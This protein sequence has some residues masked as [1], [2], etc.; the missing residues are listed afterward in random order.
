MTREECLTILGLPSQASWDEISI[1]YHDLSKVWHPDRFSDNERLRLFAEEKMKVIN[2][3]YQQLEKDPLLHAGTSAERTVRE[4]ADNTSAN[5][6]P[7]PE[8]NYEQAQNAKARPRHGQPTLSDLFPPLAIL[9]TVLAVVGFLFISASY[10]FLRPHQALRTITRNVEPR[11]TVPDSLSPAL[12]PRILSEPPPEPPRSVLQPTDAGLLQELPPKTAQPDGGT[13]ETAPAA[14]PELP[15]TEASLP[16][17]RTAEP[18]QLQIQV[19]SE[20]AFKE[21]DKMFVLVRD[22]DVV[23]RIINYTPDLL[24]ASINCDTQSVKVQLDDNA[25]VNLTDNRGD[26]ALMWAVRRRCVPVAK[27]LIEH[28]A[29]VNARSRNGF[30]A[31]VWARLVKNKELQDLLQKSG[32]DTNFG[33]YWWREDDDGKVLW[34]KHSWDALCKNGQCETKTDHPRRTARR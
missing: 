28:G 23:K 2:Q 17:D 13:A 1:M 25:D 27:L 24:D 12:I 20:D 7:R 5:A 30:T 16:I 15:Q 31:Y 9:L 29:N 6:H 11:K 21:K 19:I 33:A 3:A 14:S 18:D 4:A 34:L 22:K 32:A 8:Q 26:T 10:Y